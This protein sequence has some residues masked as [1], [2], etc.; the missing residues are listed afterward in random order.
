MLC[1]FPHNKIK[2]KKNRGEIRVIVNVQDSV[3][4]EDCVCKREKRSPEKAC[5]FIDDIVTHDGGIH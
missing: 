2:K 5:V 1:V 4:E 3:C